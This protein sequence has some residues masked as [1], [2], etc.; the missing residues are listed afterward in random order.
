VVNTPRYVRDN[1][2]VSLLS[3]CY[4]EFVR[5]LPQAGQRMMRPSGYVESQGMF[6]TRFAREIGIRLRLETPIEMARQKV[7]DEPAVCVN[8]DVVA[9]E[10]D[11]NEAKAWDELAD[12]YARRYDIARR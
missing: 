5:S 6:A 10:F 12:Y 9:S 3:E 4:C 1:I 8:S 7:F 2:H 11:W